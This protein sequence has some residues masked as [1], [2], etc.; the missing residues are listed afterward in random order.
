MN[1]VQ[2]QEYCRTNYTD[3]S[4]ITSEVEYDIFQTDLDN[5]SNDGW[6]GLRYNGYGWYWS[7]GSIAEYQRWPKVPEGDSQDECVVMKS[8]EGKWDLH[9]CEKSMPFYCYDWVPG[10]TLVQIK[11]S[12]ENALIYCRTHYSDLASLN[13][14]RNLLDVKNKTNTIV[15]TGLRFLA[16]SWFWVTRDRLELQDPLNPCPTE[17]YRCGARNPVAD[18]WEN[19]DCDEKLI[20]FCN[21]KI[22]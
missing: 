19:R 4:T 7:D 16:G 20:F 5:N 13:T 1:W 8:K 17:P 12:W 18:R 6:L 2:A 3:L 22:E 11:M 15:W 10:I 9:N 21:D 14:T